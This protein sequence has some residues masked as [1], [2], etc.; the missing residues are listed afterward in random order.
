MPQPRRNVPKA[1]ALTMIIGMVTVIIWTIAF[2]F[3]ATD[4]DEVIASP[5][6]YMT[7]YRQALRNDKVAVFFTVWLWLAYMSATTSCYATSGRLVWAFSRDNGLPFSNFFR[8][9]HPTLRMPV[10]ATSTL[11]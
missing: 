1:M 5:T 10:N 2:M 7:V 6:P 4:L 11:R 3:S 9:V 8:K